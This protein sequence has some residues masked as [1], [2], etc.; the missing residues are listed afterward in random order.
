MISTYDY[1]TSNSGVSSPF[2]GLVEQHPYPGCVELRWDAPAC[3]VM[4]EDTGIV[5]KAGPRFLVLSLLSNQ[6]RYYAA[7]ENANEIDYEVG[8]F[9][10]ANRACRFVQ[11]YLI[12]KRELL[13]ILIPRKILRARLKAQENG[14]I[15]RPNT[16]VRDCHPAQKLHPA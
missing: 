4:T 10:D 16:D 9:P 7:S 14:V 15:E 5:L 2:L 3:G 12:G 8:I 11:D 6:L 1:L 13:S